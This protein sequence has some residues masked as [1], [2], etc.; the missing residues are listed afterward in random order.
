MK[1][2]IQGSRL[3]NYIRPLAATVRQHEGIDLNNT[4]LT[5]NQC[6]DEKKYLDAMTI[7]PT[8]TA[9]MHL[10]LGS[11]PVEGEEPDI[12]TIDADAEVGMPDVCTVM[13]TSSFFALNRNIGAVQT[14]YRFADGN[15]EATTE[16]KDYFF[17]HGDIHDSSLSIPELSQDT[18]QG[19][20][21]KTTLPH[22]LACAI[23]VCRLASSKSGLK[24]Q[25]VHLCL[26]DGS[27]TVKAFS[28]KGAIIYTSE[29][30]M[31]IIDRESLA[32]HIHIAIS[33]A[34]AE[35]LS[36]M[37]SLSGNEAFWRYDSEKNTLFVTCSPYSILIRAEE[38][39][40]CHAP[41]DAPEPVIQMNRRA[42]LA[43]FQHAKKSGSDVAIVDMCKGT[44][45]YVVSSNS[46]FSTELP[47]TA[48]ASIDPPQKCVFRLPLDTMI[49]M[50][51]GFKADNV[52]LC[53]SDE[54][55]YMLMNTGECL[56]VM[57]EPL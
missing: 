33:L 26:S 1:L 14:E 29:S 28:A 25:A 20:F 5:I 10:K 31:E 21:K 16:S 52:N 51:S 56:E 44:T 50:L 49:A 54:S 24:T 17:L 57:V 4:Y 13:P 6:D 39:A 43:A 45:V 23:R 38:V 55:Q 48:N 37:C 35:T 27:F 2:S 30:D 40:E 7:Q 3:L 8:Y 46:D 18:A 15:L 22:A 11:K 34:A 9:M 12:D 41:T 32:G 53:F 36:M 42:L 19:F 47:A